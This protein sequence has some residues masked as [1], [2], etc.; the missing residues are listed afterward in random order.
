MIS[1]L[2]G[3]LAG[4]EPVLQAGVWAYVV[5]PE[6]DWPVAMEDV[7]GMVR[8]A[9]GVTLI[10]REEVALAAGLE[11]RF[12]CAW[13][14][15]EVHSDLAGVGLTAAFAGALAEVGISCNVMAGVFHDHLF[16][17][18]GD[19]ARAMVALRALQAAHV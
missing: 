9:A 17:P 18:E 3:M 12:R 10:L 8:E 11:V 15:L 4:M 2:K 6:G 7:A 5:V 14:T 13:I 16:V 19:G 1:D